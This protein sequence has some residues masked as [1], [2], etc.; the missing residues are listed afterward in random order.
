MTDRPAKDISIEYAHIYTNDKIG[1]EHKLSLQILGQLM[2]ER[3][4]Q[5]ESSSLVVMIDDYSFPDPAFDYESFV[6]WLSE[7]GYKPDGYFRESQLLSVCDSVLKLVT[8]SDLRNQIA[9]YIR[10]KKYPCSLFVAAWYLLR[11]GLISSPAFDHGLTGKKVVNILPFSL[12][13]FEDK[14]MEIIASTKFAACISDIDT[15]YFEG[16]LVA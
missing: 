5:R 8:D 4:I 7:N 3:S 1:D 11:L 10:S 16:R 6:S 12:K 2:K 15:R 9:S 13:P 14:A